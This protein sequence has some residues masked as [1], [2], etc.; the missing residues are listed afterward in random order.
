MSMIYDILGY[1]MIALIPSMLVLGC[2][3]AEILSI[4]NR[5]CFAGVT[6]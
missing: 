3:C 2:C 1:V 6:I 4:K 5:L